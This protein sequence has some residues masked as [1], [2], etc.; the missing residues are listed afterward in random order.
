MTLCCPYNGLFPRRRKHLL[1]SNEDQQ[2][3]L[4]ISPANTMS[5]VTQA[6]PMPCGLKQSS[7]LY[8]LPHQT[9]QEE[10]INMIVLWGKAWKQQTLQDSSSSALSLCSQHNCFLLREVCA[11]CISAGGVCSTPKSLTLVLGIVSSLLSLLS[12]SPTLF[13]TNTAWKAL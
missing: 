11:A 2:S 12:Y 1:I 6:L 13:F 4:L 3:S 8:L 7:P 10:S 9:L 5:K